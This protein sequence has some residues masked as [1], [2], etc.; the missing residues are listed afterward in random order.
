MLRTVRILR[1][2]RLIS[3]IP[4][5]LVLYTTSIAAVQMFGAIEPEHFGHLGA[6]L[7]TMFKVMTQGRPDVADKI[8]EVRPLGW[9]FF[10]GYIVLTE[11]AAM[12]E[13]LTRLENQLR[14]RSD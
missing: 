10:L 5:A 1:T 12:R 2:F 3:V 13:Q 4:L 7:L 6:A 14:A 11:L 9:L 8:V